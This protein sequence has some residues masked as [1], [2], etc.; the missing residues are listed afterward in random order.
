[1]TPVSSYAD[2]S[3]LRQLHPAAVRAAVRFEQAGDMGRA[4]VTV[5]N[6]GTAVAFFVQLDIT[7]GGNGV[8]PIEWSDNYVS[9]L[10]GEA[11]RLV[12]RYRLRDL[13]GATP[14]LEVSGW[15]VAPQ[16]VRDTP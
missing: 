13:R 6:T 5:E 9:L 11:R 14:V 15:N 2:F 4:Q 8:L 10:P 16:A 7:A 1:M 3:G 12:A